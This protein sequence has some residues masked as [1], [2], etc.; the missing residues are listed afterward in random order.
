MLHTKF[1]GTRSAFLEKK[2]FEGLLPYIGMA[3]I[4]V[5]SSNFHFLVPESFEVLYNFWSRTAQ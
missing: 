3:V 1:H 2:V 5:M 4:L